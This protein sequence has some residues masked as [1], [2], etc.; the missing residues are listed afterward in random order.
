MTEPIDVR[1]QVTAP[2]AGEG[3]LRDQYPMDLEGVKLTHELV[4]IALKLGSEVDRLM[5]ALEKLSLTAPVNLRPAILGLVYLGKSAIGRGLWATTKDVA[6]MKK[7]LNNPTV[8]VNA[9]SAYHV[10]DYTDAVGEVLGVI[11]AEIDRLNAKWQAGHDALEDLDSE[12]SKRIGQEL[13]T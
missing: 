11:K 6:Y 3:K 7:Q 13:G 5:G 12:T 9:E 10:F 1:L 4:A 2:K 8:I